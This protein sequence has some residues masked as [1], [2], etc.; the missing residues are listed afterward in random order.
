M[1]HCKM[2]DFHFIC[3][4]FIYSTP[5]Y[6]FI[7]D[8]YIYPHYSKLKFILSSWTKKV[9]YLEFSFREFPR[10]YLC[11]LRIISKSLNGDNMVYIGPVSFEHQLFVFHT[12]EIYLWF[13]SLIFLFAST[14][15]DCI[16]WS[17]DDFY[18]RF[19]SNF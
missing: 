1:C 10:L 18:F 9:E 11:W 8:N 12:F 14:I 17:M 3:L 7:Y 2:F 6:I 16:L 13:A 5:K 15:Y 4:K 19:H